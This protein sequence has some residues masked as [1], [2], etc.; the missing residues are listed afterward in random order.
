MAREE[1][2]RDA[3]F[4]KA[5]LLPIGSHVTFQRQ[6]GTDCFRADIYRRDIMKHWWATLTHDQ[7]NLPVEEIAERIFAPLCAA[8]LAR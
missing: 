1:D 4:T 3:L 6:P 8:A 7:M 5:C 2:I